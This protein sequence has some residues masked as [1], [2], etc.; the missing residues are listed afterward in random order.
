[1]SN[2]NSKRVQYIN[3]N[4]LGR[5]REPIEIVQEE[6]IEL[7]MKEL[8]TETTIDRNEVIDMCQDL[9][10]GELSSFHRDSMMQYLNYASTAQFPPQM[11]ALDASQPW[12]VYWIANSLAT[13]KPSSI[14][15]EL[16]RKIVNKLFT[17]S[18]E[19]G[20]FGGGSGQLPH[21]AGTYA[22]INA[23]SLCDNIDGC[24]DEIN[25]PAIY[26]WLLSLKQPDN[27]FITCNPVGE[28][29]TRGTYCALSV[30]SMLGIMTD[31]LT[32]GVA[33][34]L[35]S[36]QTYEGGYGG[37]PVGDEA[38]GGYTFCAVASLFILG[39]SDLIDIEGLMEWCSA[40]QYNEE[41]GLSGRNNKLVDGC[42]SF[43]VGA[44][45]AMIEA[46]TGVECLDKSALQR[47]ILNCCQSD[48]RPGFR[49]KPGKSPDFYHTNYVLLGLAY[50]ESS[51]SFKDSRT[52]NPFAITST[53]RKNV[54]N[55]ANLIP[56]SPIY[57]LPIDS[58]NKFHDHFVTH[59]K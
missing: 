15:D 7:I 26:D 28:T 34:Y 31:E 1:M 59:K 17:I 3:S 40:R 51:F 8:E 29:D 5:K 30:A 9:L 36:C 38:H 22:A 13:V 23:L 14:D 44:T 46:L 56:I 18:P 42:Y 49:D 43:W 53:Q 6:P 35:E 25:K 20:P 16:K 11:T 52:D 4:L 54:E 10:E 37:T 58:L 2:K 27:S 45:A 19:K 47:Y 57:G 12:M 48:E 55:S 32:A 21:I 24:W 41:M 39:R 33:E 50:A